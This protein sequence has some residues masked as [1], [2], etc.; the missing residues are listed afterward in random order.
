[1]VGSSES[2]CQN[3]AWNPIPQCRQAW[4]QLQ[5]CEE[6]PQIQNGRILTRNY[7]GDNQPSP[8]DSVTYECYEGYELFGS[9]KAYC[10]NATLTFKPC[11]VCNGNIF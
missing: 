9:S 11:P 10:E 3:G 4:Q 7:G 5:V 2:K 8:G 6:P 1:M